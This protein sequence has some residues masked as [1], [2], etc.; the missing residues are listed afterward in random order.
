MRLR[1]REESGWLESNYRR[2]GNLP[3]RFSDA[4]LAN[5]HARDAQQK[6][7]LAVATEFVDKYPD[8]GLIG[9]SLVFIGKAGTGK[10]HLGCAIANQLEKTARVTYG[11]VADVAR[12]VRT[13]HRGNQTQETENEILDRIATQPD[14]LV[15]DEVG[16]NLDSSAHAELVHEIIDRRYRSQRSLILISNLDRNALTPYLGERAMDRL[17]EVARVVPF[18]WQS[19]RSAA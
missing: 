16:L 8:I 7:A 18:A 5:F 15:L 19:E 14:L 1:H 17:R 9:G 11:T 4:S 2:F 6:A 12:E 13:G 3:L 10:T